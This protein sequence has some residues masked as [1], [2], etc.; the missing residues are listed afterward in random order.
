MRASTFILILLLAAPGAA[1]AAP[2]GGAG[3]SGPPS[4]RA[5]L[6]RVIAAFPDQPLLIHGEVL[7]KNRQGSTE[8]RILLDME[9]D[10]KASPATA[11]YTLRDAFG[12]AEKHLAITWPSEGS[13]EYRYF[14]GDPLAAAPLPVLSKSID[15]TDLSWMDL[16]L[17]FLWW[18]K[19]RTVGEEEVKGRT[20][21]VLDLTAPAGAYEGCAGVRV[22]IDPEIPMLLRAASYDPEGKLSRQLDVRS[23]KKIGGRWMI[24]NIEV[25]SHPAKH[26]TV[27]RVTEARDRTRKD[28]TSPQEQA[29]PGEAPAEPS[30]EPQEPVTPVAPVPV[31]L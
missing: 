11:R 24:Q 30:A 16:S 10:W 20:C 25:V 7:A 26:R 21:T 1:P 8:Q 2:E 31:D 27:L 9:L 22:W 12:K 15:R 6:D 19:A 28:F 3:E 4:A 13:P 14:E 18:D 17:S 29:G 23:F 5:L